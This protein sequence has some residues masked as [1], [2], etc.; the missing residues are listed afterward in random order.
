MA[1]AAV[2]GLPSPPVSQAGEQ[3]AVAALIYFL[4][5][6]NHWQN[7]RLGRE[8]ML[9]DLSTLPPLSFRERGMPSW[10]EVEAALAR[11]LAKFPE[12]R[13]LVDGGFRRRARCTNRAAGSST[14]HTENVT[15]FPVT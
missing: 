3:H 13:V 1:R 15:A 4:M 11:A 9:K 2:A 5:T 8:E 14:A 7:F 12:E 6:G 10:P